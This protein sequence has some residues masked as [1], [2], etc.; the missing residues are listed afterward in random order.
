[1]TTLDF[2]D[3]ENYRHNSRITGLNDWSVSGAPTALNNAAR[4]G[5]I[6][7]AMSANMTFTRPFPAS[8]TGQRTSSFYFNLM[9]WGSLFSPAHS[10]MGV[11]TMSNMFVSCYW[12]ITGTRQVAA[13][14]ANGTSTQTSVETLDLNTWYRAEWS[15]F[16]ADRLEFNNTVVIYE[17][18]SRIPKLS[19]GSRA[20]GPNDRVRLGP[21]NSSGTLLMYM[22]TITLAD[23]FVGPHDPVN[24]FLH[25]P[26]GGTP[27]NNPAL[28]IET[29]SPGGR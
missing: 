8:D 17:G 13:N 24:W 19:V 9:N 1:M 16:Q 3:F 10:R 12:E 5:D 22:D 6:G 14:N 11:A 23:D 2:V 7:A 15:V 29:S 18:E 20:N 27:L 4:H 21:G 25:S 26:E 28:V